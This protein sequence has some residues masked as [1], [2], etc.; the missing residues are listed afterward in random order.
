M[1][2]RWEN[3]GPLPD[4]PRHLKDED[5]RLIIVRGDKETELNFEKPNAFG[6]MLFIFITLT[7]FWV[8]VII[9]LWRLSG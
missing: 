5:F 3:D 1:L 6:I 4:D 8:V 2:K 7:L 9:Q